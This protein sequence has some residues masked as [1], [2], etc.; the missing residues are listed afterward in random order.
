VKENQ[1]PGK[2]VSKAPP[3]TFQTGNARIQKK[4]HSLGKAQEIRHDFG[5]CWSRQQKNTCT[6]DAG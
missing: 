4:V 6:I 5:G 2:G 3:S 1:N